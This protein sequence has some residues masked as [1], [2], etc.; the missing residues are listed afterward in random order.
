MTDNVAESLEKFKKVLLTITPQK[1]VSDDTF[2]EKIESY[3]TFTGNLKTI[4]FLR[5]FQVF[6]YQLKNL[7]S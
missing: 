6:S 4:C 2:L 1:V 3:L 5:V 7:I